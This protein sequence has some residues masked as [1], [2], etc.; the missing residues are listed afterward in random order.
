MT[1]RRIAGWLVL[2]F[3]GVCIGF[4]VGFHFGFQ[5]GW[6]DTW[7]TVDYMRVENIDLKT[8]IKELQQP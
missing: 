1:E 7:T 4:A 5:Q 2:V 3:V 8:K 6:E